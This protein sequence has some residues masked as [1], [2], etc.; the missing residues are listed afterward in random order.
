VTALR[1]GGNL[2]AARIREVCDAHGVSHK[3]DRRTR[4]GEKLLVVKNRRNALAHGDL[5]FVECGRDYTV[6]ELKEIK[7]QSFWYLKAILRNIDR[8]N[9]KKTYRK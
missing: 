2:D 5:S 7:M 4:G 1:F 3:T 8:F 9:T 6:A